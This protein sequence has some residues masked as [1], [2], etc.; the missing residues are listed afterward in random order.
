MSSFSLSA[1]M[2]WQPAW[3]VSS[4]HDGMLHILLLLVDALR[5]QALWNLLPQQCS[6]VYNLKNILCEPPQHSSCSPMQRCSA[7]LLIMSRSTACPS[8][9]HAKDDVR[10]LQHNRFEYHSC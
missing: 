5:L 10:C 8:R 6:Q 1:V 3:A 2:W 9:L 7:L 4:C